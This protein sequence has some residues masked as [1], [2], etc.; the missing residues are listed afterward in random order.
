MGY[1]G[2]APGNDANFLFMRSPIMSSLPL[3]KPSFQKHSSLNVTIPSK[4]QHKFHTLKKTPGPLNWIVLWPGTLSAWA[5]DSSC[6]SHSHVGTC[7]CNTVRLAFFFSGPNQ[8][9][10]R[11]FMCCLSPSRVVKP[12]DLGQG[13][14]E[15]SHKNFLSL[16]LHKTMSCLLEESDC[17]FEHSFCNDW[18]TDSFQWN[19]SHNYYM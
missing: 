19:R 3:R 15:Q 12:E 6:P 16:S 5:L 10:F 9:V 14:L 13:G 1:L 18:C 7:A 8:M 11:F 17:P 2:V 4:G